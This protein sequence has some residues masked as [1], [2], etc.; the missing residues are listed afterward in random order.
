M[1]SINNLKQKH[2]QYTAYWRT[3]DPS[4]IF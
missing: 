3:K 4:C 1:S 2:F